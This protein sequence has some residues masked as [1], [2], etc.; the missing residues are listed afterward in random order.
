MNWILAY[1]FFGLFLAASAVNLV[2]GYNEWERGRRRSKPFCLLFLALA[3]MCA[4]PKEPLIY[5]GAFLGM[6]GDVLLLWKSKRSFLA[7][8]A[9]S[10]FL[11]HACYVIEMLL[12]MGGAGLLDWPVYGYMILVAVLVELV[13][14]PTIYFF[15]KKSKPFTAIGVFYST[16]LISVALIALQGTCWGYAK[17]FSLVLA[18]AV[19][20]IISDC[21]LALTLFRHDLKR[22]DFWIMLTYLMG[23]ALIVC[24]LLYTVL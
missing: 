3:A 1:L 16:I 20:F 11:G 23:E 15:T 10:F 7:L 12:I 24:G 19:S 8:G 17:W 18:G 4:A 5:V 14:A 9:A 6:A 21:T 22:R 2:C 13:A